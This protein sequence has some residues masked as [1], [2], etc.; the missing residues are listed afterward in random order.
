[1]WNE[2]SRKHLLIKHEETIDF[3]TSDSCSLCRDTMK[4]S[5]FKGQILCWKPTNCP[6][7][8]SQI[9]ASSSSLARRQ[10]FQIQNR[11]WGVCVKVGPV[12]SKSTRIDGNFDLQDLVQVFH[13]AQS[14]RKGCLWQRRRIFIWIFKIAIRPASIQ[15][16][17]KG[18]PRS[19]F[20][21]RRLL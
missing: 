18:E 19:V 6:T 12:D 14:V 11:H 5:P 7:A 20:Q 1:M 3:W 10:T 9:G 13:F 17:L 8:W 4:T 15:A 21:I 2:K 16:T